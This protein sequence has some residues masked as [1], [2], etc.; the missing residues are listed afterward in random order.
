M[1]LERAASDA[2]RAEAS[3]RDGNARPLEGVPFGVKDL[4]DTA[5]VRTTYG[6]PMFDDHVPAQDAGAVARM[7]EAGGILAGKT[8]T[9]EFAYGIAG[10]NPHY[11]AVRNPWDEERVSGGS[12]SG[13]GAALAA[14]LVPLT[15][16]S[17]TGG[18]IRSPPR[19]VESSG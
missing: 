2:K 19:T 5:G 7:L 11:G 4:F 12:S 15:L 13:S 8:S 14:R 9:D 1:T 16:G 18:S 10:V 6:S 17:D 3:W